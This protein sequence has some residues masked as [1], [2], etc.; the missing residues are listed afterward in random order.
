MLLLF[1]LSMF[2]KEEREIAQYQFDMIRNIDAFCNGFYLHIV[3]LFMCDTNK[4]KV[5]LSQI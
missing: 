4:V 2:E 1:L 3:P 5:R